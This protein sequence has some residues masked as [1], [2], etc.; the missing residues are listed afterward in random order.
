MMAISSLLLPA[1]AQRRH[2]TSRLESFS[3]PAVTATKVFCRHSKSW[4]AAKCSSASSGRVSGARVPEI[5]LSGDHG[6]IAR[7]RR[8]Q[9]LAKTRQV[10][11]ELLRSDDSEK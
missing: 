6:A 9:A 8:E 11:P 10:R 3:R 5:L 7:W 1:A 2:S 4:R